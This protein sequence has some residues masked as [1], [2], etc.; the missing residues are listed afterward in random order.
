MKWTDGVFGCQ[1]HR[2]RLAMGYRMPRQIY[3]RKAQELGWRNDLNR[4]T[5]DNAECGAQSFVT[6]KDFVQALFQCFLAKTSGEAQGEMHVVG[7]VAG[8]DLV[9]K[10]QPLLG[11]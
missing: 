1:T 9:K 11:K 6:A 10:P 8:V 5:C 3:D 2:F 7:G 4:L